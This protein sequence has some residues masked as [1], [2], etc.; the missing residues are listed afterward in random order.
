MSTFTPLIDS[1]VSNITPPVLISPACKARFIG[2]S[3]VYK[4]KRKNYP[5]S[6]RGTINYK[7]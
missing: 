4:R 1:E 7:E 2:P 3:V 6:G 5:N